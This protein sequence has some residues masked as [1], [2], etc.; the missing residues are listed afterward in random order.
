MVGGLH[1]PNARCA[2][3][4]LPPEHRLHQRTPDAAVLRVGIDADG[5]DCCDRPT[6]VDEQD[7]RDRTLPLGD[8]AEDPFGAEHA[9]DGEA[10][11]LGRPGLDREVVPP[12]DRREGGEENPCAGVGVLRRGPA[13]DECLVF[14]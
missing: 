10:R 2:A 5:A 6:L 9:A 13:N 14:F 4:P 12:G 7:P 8:Q 11:E 1:E 3:L